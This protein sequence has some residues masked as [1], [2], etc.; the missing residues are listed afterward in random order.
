MAQKELKHLDHHETAIHKLI[1]DYQQAREKSDAESLRDLLTKDADQLVS[2]GVWRKGRGNL[3][4]GMQRSSQTNRGKRSINVEQIRFLSREVAI[5]DAR[6]I[7]ADRDGIRDR[8]MWSTF[9]VKH[10]DEK[11]RI[12]AIRNMLPALNNQ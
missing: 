12:S 4:E 11:W 6:Y 9:V 8:K 5:A 2:S 7:I 1:S 10:S 3:V